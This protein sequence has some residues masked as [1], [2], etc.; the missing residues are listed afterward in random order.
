MSEASF[1]AELHDEEDQE[2]RSVRWTPDE[3][4]ARAFKA[5]VISFFISPV[6]FYS[7]WLLVKLAATEGKVSPAVRWKLYAAVIINVAFFAIWTMLIMLILPLRS[8]LSF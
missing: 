6:L 3:L 5:A 2:T 8:C 7:T 1:A 4:A